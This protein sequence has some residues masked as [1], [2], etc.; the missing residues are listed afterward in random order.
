ML[1]NKI[2][3]PLTISTGLCHQVFVTRFR[4]DR[5][6]SAQIVG[7]FF[8]PSRP[9]IPWIP[10]IPCV[11]IR[12]VTAM[13]LLHGL[14]QSVHLCWTGYQMDLIGHQAIADQRNA[15]QLNVLSQQVQIHPA[16]CVAVE[17]ESA[18]IATLGYVVRH[19]NSDHSGQA[20]HD[21]HSNRKMV[22]EGIF[23]RALS[24][25]QLSMIYLLGLRGRR[26][27]N[28][29]TRYSAVITG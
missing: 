21:S 23:R 10:W 25:A 28:I 15:V 19:S 22:N 6:R 4:L 12:R 13:C 18:A 24:C 5:D 16:V 11:P 1:N 9:R 26:S 14:C 7:Q 29:C 27:T 2:I 3:E 8:T 17:K 20:C